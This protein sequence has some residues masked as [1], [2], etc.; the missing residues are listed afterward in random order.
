[1]TQPA[2]RPTAALDGFFG[3]DLAQS[4]P[5]VFGAIQHELERQQLA[6]FLRLA[7]RQVEPLVEARARR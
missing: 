7:H 4:D 3:M 5:D 6:V 1:M 2:S